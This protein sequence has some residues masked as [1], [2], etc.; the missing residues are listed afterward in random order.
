MDNDRLVIHRERW[1]DDQEIREVSSGL[2]NNSYLLE[3]AAVAAHPKLRCTQKDLVD[4]T[5][6][7]KALIGTVLA[8]LEKGGLIRRLGTDGREHPFQRVQ[9]GVWASLSNFLAE[10]RSLDQ[11]D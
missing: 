9:S 10:L 3:V 7:D 4:A 11:L 2:F 1:M 8:R 6:I 5:H